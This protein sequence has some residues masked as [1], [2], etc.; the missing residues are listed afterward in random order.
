MGRLDH[1]FKDLVNVS[2][3]QI[4]QQE[5]GVLVFRIVPGSGY[6][7]QDSQ[8]LLT[9]AMKRLGEDTDIVLEFVD[10]LPR[11]KHG[12]LR[13]VVSELDEASLT[14]AGRPVSTT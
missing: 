9:E 11:T 2:A 3:A 4:V 10:S 12:K 5:I 7:E 1:I 13:L 14:H 8:F 6:S